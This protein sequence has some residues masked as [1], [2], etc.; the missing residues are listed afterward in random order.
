LETL[1]KVRDGIG[2]RIRK[3][4]DTEGLSARQFGGRVGVSQRYIN[5]LEKGDRQPSQALVI[6]IALKMGVDEDW[7]R[8]GQRSRKR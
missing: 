7:L 8:T 5:M 4:R 2:D 6:A 3:A 1:E